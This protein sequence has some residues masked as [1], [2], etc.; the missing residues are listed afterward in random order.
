MPPEDLD[1]EP[2]ENG[3]TAA[4][5]ARKR[6]RR[7]SRGGKNRRKREAAASGVAAPAGEP[8]SEP[9]APAAEETP[10]NFDYVPMSQWGDEFE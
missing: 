10:E 1:D 2:S 5:P 3:D 7:G 8:E 6:T 4:A 9:E